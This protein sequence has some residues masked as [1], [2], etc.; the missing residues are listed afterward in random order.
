MNPEQV[1]DAEVE[2]LGLF[3]GVDKKEIGTMTAKLSGIE[4]HS[5][6]PA[7]RVAPDGRARADLVI[8]I[9]QRFQLEP[10][11]SGRF[12]GG[13]TLLVDLEENEVRYFVRKRVD[14]AARVEAQ[15]NFQQ[16]LRD[17]LRDTYFAGSLQEA[18]PFAMLHRRH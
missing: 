7:R 10:P 3:R 8:E 15:L 17:E 12:R 11:R 1:T 6:R 18:E 16:S 2:A 5:V 14:S 4:V 9:T 13:C